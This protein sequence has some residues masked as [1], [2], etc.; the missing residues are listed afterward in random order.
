MACREPSMESTGL[1]GWTSDDLGLIDDHTG[2]DASLGPTRSGSGM[3]MDPMLSGISTGYPEYAHH[4]TEAEMEAVTQVMSEAAVSRITTGEFDYQVMAG[5]AETGESDSGAPDELPAFHGDQSAMFKAVQR[6]FLI[7]HW[8]GAEIGRPCPYVFLPSDDIFRPSPEAD[9]DVSLTEKLFV[10]AVLCDRW[11]IDS[12]ISSGTFGR[13]WV[14]IDSRSNQKVFIKTFRSLND[15]SRRR[16]DPA[17]QEDAVRREVEVLLHP[18]FQ[19]ATS[20]PAVVSNYLCFGKV[21]VPQT[22]MTGEMFFIMTPDLCDGGELFYYLC[23]QTKPY[24][25]SFSAGTARILFRMIANGVAHMHEVGCYHRDLKLENLVVTAEFDVKIMDFGSVKF[26]DQL[27]TVV[28]EEGERHIASTYTVGTSGYK[29]REANR[30]FRG[31]DD[32]PGYE[33]WKLDVWS[34]GAILFFMVVGEVLYRARGQAFFSF[35]EQAFVKQQFEDLL[36]AE[37]AEVDADYGVP[38]HNKLWQFLEEANG[39]EFDT[40]LKVCINTMLDLNPSRRAN[41]CEI[42]DMDFLRERDITEIVY[43]AEMR[44]RQNHAGRDLAGEDAIKMAEIMS[45]HEGLDL[46]GVKALLIAALPTDTEG[47]V[48]PFEDH[49]DTIDVGIDDSAE[50]MFRIQ[51]HGEDINVYWM[52]GSLIQWLEFSIS[53]KVNLGLGA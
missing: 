5:A 16:A 27:T 9:V 20:H 13:G 30:E 1:S 8:K 21:E 50:A 36:D 52:R 41:M 47:Q 48:H 25:R 32:Q 22:G 6:Y 35:V 46:E 42:L 34:C 17:V 10:D 29:S 38:S 26:R 12:Y 14:G 24:V 11:K 28:T 31:P 23:P 45:M 19:L 4:V 7:S 33:P 2:S 15:R 43:V 37:G 18:A 39:E 49:G 44:S 40:D 3:E 51:F 53:L